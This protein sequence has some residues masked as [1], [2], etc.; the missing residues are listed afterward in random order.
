M[1]T[2]LLLLFSILLCSATSQDTPSPTP[3]GEGADDIGGY[4]FRSQSP[5]IDVVA[6]FGRGSPTKIPTVKPSFP[7]TPE[8]GEIIQILIPDTPVTGGGLVNNDIIA[9]ETSNGDAEEEKEITDMPTDMPTTISP[10][11]PEQ[12]APFVEVAAAVT[13]QNSAMMMGSTA[14][15]GV[16]VV[17]MLAMLGFP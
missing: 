4:V 5:T 7:P 2:L 11:I 9:Q 12:D 1:N 10:T 3:K 16:V 14:I 17:G 6:Q 13:D 8:D 15:L